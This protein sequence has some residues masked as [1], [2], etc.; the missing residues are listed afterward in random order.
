[1]ETE[2]AAALKLVRD[3]LLRARKVVAFSG[4]GISE[5]SGIPTFRGSGGL[6][7]SHPIEEVATPQAFQRNPK[8]VWDFYLERRRDALRAKPNPAHVAIAGWQERFS[9]CGVVTQNVDG[10]HRAAGSRNIQELHGNLW[11]SRCTQCERVSEYRAL[12]ARDLAPCTD[13]GG[14]MRPH[15][16]WFGESLDPEVL[17]TSARWMRDADMVFVIGTSGV[18]EPAASLVRDA[19]RCAVFTVELNLSKTALTPVVDVSLFGKCGVIF[20]RADGSGLL[21]Q[22]PNRRRTKLSRWLRD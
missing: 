20:S 22:A 16:V 11:Q 3:R 7:N 15:I 2:T 12:E 9:F 1:M 21:E 4:A 13:C 19:K 8:L 6:W 14:L 18:V 5:E 10:L 17:A